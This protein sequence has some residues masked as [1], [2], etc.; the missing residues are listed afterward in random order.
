MKLKLILLTVLS[1]F[2]C[3]NIRAEEPLIK[4]GVVTDLHY[5]PK[6]EKNKKHPQRMYKISNKKLQEAVNTFN[7]ENVAFTAILGD[8]IDK[9]AESFND[10]K[11]ILKT[12]NNPYHIALGNHDFIDVYGSKAQN[13]ALKILG[14]KKPYYS[15]VKNN[16]RFIFLD[17]NDLALYSRGENTPEGKEIRALYNKL[18][19]EKARSASKYNGTLSQKQIDW[20][21]K[22]IE[23]SQ[24]KNQQ[25]ICFAHMPLLP[26]NIGGTDMQGKKISQI[27]EKYPNV[28]AY[29]SGHHHEGSQYLKTSVKYYNFQGM[30]EGNNNHYSVVSLYKDRLEVKGYGE[31]ESTTIRF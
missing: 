9:Y 22:L 19:A 21:V 28:K 26:T 24:K 17:S 18:K 14:V 12:L 27:L 10:L 30:I 4:F 25:V 2:L 1:A 31:Q 8:I 11:P 16:I 5:S 20:M 3:N 15:F 7:Q 6:H 13:E 29:L 23:K